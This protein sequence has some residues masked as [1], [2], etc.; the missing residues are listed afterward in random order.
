MKIS[1]GAICA[2]VL[3][4]LT[5]WSHAN[6]ERTLSA[7]RQFVLYGTDVAL[8][9][10]I[11]NLA[12]ET[13]TNLLTLLRRSDSWKTPIVINLQFPQANV[14][15]IPSA[16]LQFSQTGAGLKLQL[17]LTIAAN[18]NSAAVE[19]ELLRAILLEMIY[20]NQLDIA[21][22]TVYVDPPDWLLE[23]VT[24]IARGR[25]AKALADALEPLLAAEKITSLSEFF[26]PRKL[27]GLDSPG[28]LLYRAHAAAFMK[29]LLD[30]PQGRSQ[31]GRYID[32]LANASNDP[33]ADLRIYFPALRDE[34]VEKQWRVRISRFCEAQDF[35]LLTFE[36]TQRRLNE[37]LTVKTEDSR[38]G[39]TFRLEDLPEKKISLAQARA[40]R[41]LSQ[42][43][44]LL[45]AR[46]NPI[47]RPIV[48]EYQEVAERL[49]A[50]KSSGAS[51]RLARTRSLRAKLAARLDKIDDY[52]NW[53]EA[54]QARS[55]SDTF[56]NYLN[57][58]EARQAAPRRSDPI[59][60]YLDSLEEQF[61]D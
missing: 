34:A 19:R 30:D 17:D 38:S 7:S 61:Q 57:A 12:E 28:R 2:L 47:L 36:Q 9:G 15:E 37:L 35:R 40:L 23:G 16:A 13:K 56:T 31:F 3:A 46:A 21:P 45:K 42:K 52:M 43:L 8:R 20:R 44:I 25:N 26:R 48:T 54:T 32:N 60:V 29:W 27:S 24:A 10:A 14:P 6:P 22:G 59:S 39:T 5:I 11:S 18:F 41:Q 33:L 1:R 53:F 51:E 4:F 55:K 58:A 49:A 50:G